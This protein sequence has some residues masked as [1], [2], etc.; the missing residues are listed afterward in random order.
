VMTF[1]LIFF[2]GVPGHGFGY[3]QNESEFP[4]RSSGPI[5]FDLDLCQFAGVGD[6]TRIEIYYSVYLTGHDSIKIEGN[7]YTT[8]DVFLKLLSDSGKVLLKIQEEKTISFSDSEQSSQNTT[9][10][11]LKSFRLLPDSVTIQLIIQDKVTGKTGQVIKPLNIRYF[12]NEFSLSDLYF[13]SHIQRATG[14][15]LFERHGVMLVPH[16]SRT[17]F[18]SDDSQKAFIFYEINNLSF[19]TSQQSFYD[20]IATVFDIKGQEVFKNVKELIKV[21]STNSSRIEIIPIGNL[22]SGIYKILVHV[23][24]RES[25]IRREISSRFKILREDSNDTNVLPMSDEESQK[26]FDQIKYIATDRELTIYDQLNPQGKQ[27]FLLQ[28]WKSRDPNPNT[29]E[30]E[31]MLEHFRR[32]A[33]VEAQFKGGINSDM[34]RIY[35]IYG[36]PLEIQRQALD[37]HITHSVEKWIY[38]LRGRTEFVFVDRIGD[39]KYALV[40]ST[41]LEEFS[42]PNWQQDL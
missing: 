30:N 12:D 3:P 32:L 29:P 27:E 39:G 22:N 6:T 16:P 35:I 15:S 40:H 8:L 4:I 38:T 28:F 20:A 33:E 21:G 14:G 18:I 34:G 10:I 26:Y 5:K 25:G 7:N 19:D 9:F 23:L 36:S 41:Y 11:D 2:I 1:G 24:D 31:F 17:Y 42:N 37:V 13:V